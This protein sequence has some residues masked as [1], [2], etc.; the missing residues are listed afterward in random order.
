M[1][2]ILLI[3]LKLFKLLNFGMIMLQPG[4]FP[5]GG[6]SSGPGGGLGNGGPPWNPGDPDIPIAQG[7]I[8]LLFAAI[9]L[10]I[11]F[12]QKKK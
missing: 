8:V 3:L 4:S 1:N 5:G 7:I 2:S 11:R 12:F 9:G 6:N 10:G